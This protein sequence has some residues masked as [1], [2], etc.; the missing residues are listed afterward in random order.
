MTVIAEAKPAVDLLDLAHV[1]IAHLLDTAPTTTLDAV[2]QRLFDPRN[3]ELLTV[4][5]FASAL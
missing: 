2:M 5:A 1:R 3:R 4:S